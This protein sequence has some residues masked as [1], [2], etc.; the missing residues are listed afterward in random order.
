M[1]NI[2]TWEFTEILNELSHD[3]H[4]TSTYI[5]SHFS[6][7]PLSFWLS[8]V[9]HFFFF[10][11][12]QNRHGVLWMQLLT[13]SK[14]CHNSL[15][16]H[17]KIRFLLTKKLGKKLTA[18]ALAMHLIW[19]QPRLP[20]FLQ[21]WQEKGYGRRKKKKIRYI[22]LEYSNSR[23]MSTACRI[24]GKRT[25]KFVLGDPLACTDHCVNL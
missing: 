3:L 25:S 18:P 6:A 15:G 1:N 23:V 9:T 2:C 11:V 7:W 13:D 20:L 12:H 4:L 10:G 24:F 5:F 17:E 22:G 19:V 8:N 16:T 14:T 21:E